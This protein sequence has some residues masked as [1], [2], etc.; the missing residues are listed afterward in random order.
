MARLRR[1]SPL[2]T[3]GYTDLAK[4]GYISLWAE[5]IFSVR[6]IMVYKLLYHMFE[7]EKSHEKFERRHSE[8]EG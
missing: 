1:Q 6:T 2:L 4:S 3:S 7:Q 8:V 5:P